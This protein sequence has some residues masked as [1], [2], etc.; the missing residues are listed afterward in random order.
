MTTA[1]KPAGEVQVSG[2]SGQVP[3]GVAGR[4][5]TAVLPHPLCSGPGPRPRGWARCGPRAKSCPYQ[6]EKG[7]SCNL[8]INRTVTPALQ[9]PPRKPVPSR[10]AQLELQGVAGKLC[11]VPYL[12]AEALASPH[13]YPWSTA[14]VLLVSSGTTSP[15]KPSLIRPLPFKG[16]CVSLSSLKHL[17][18]TITLT[19]CIV[20]TCF[21]GCLQFPVVLA[22]SRTGTELEN[23]RGGRA[24]ERIWPKPL[25][26]RREAQRGV[27]V[28]SGSHS[29]SLTELGAT[30]V[31]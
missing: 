31:A 3:P 24:P 12:Q 21:C 14:L 15:R 7:D 4:C 10:P 1:P 19:P 17:S 9:P 16:S 26:N 8:E 25:S 5:R 20:G 30:V 28:C 27:R 23:I 18:P 22:Q 29:M 6:W 2:R 11:T 13:S